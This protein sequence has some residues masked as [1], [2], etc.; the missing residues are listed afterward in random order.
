MH[1]EGRVEAVV[2]MG[3]AR[4]LGQSGISRNLRTTG[5]RMTRQIP[6]QRPRRK[7]KAPTRRS[8]SAADAAMKGEGQ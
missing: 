8:T 3:V 5:A 7:Q 4:R 2:R 6:D 1:T